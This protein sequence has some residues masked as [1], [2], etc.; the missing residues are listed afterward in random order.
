M[1]LVAWPSTNALEYRRKNRRPKQ[2]LKNAFEFCLGGV[3]IGVFLQE[4][5]VAWS[6]PPRLLVCAVPLVCAYCVFCFCCLLLQSTEH[7]AGRS[8]IEGFF[9]SPSETRCSRRS[10]LL[11][12]EER[13]TRN[14]NYYNFKAPYARPEVNTLHL[15]LRRREYPEQTVSA[16]IYDAVT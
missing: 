15:L 11:S 12:R 6:P 2:H 13:P 9:S 5:K 3:S 8:G 16:V 1:K 14:P 7:S 4:L 10:Y